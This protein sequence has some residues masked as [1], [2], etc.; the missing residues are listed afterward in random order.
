VH[1]KSR[2]CTSYLPSTT[3]SHKAASS[4]LAIAVAIAVSVLVVV[5][6]VSNG[7][8]GRNIVRIDA[9]HTY[10]NKQKQ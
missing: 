4:V 8:I 7:L 6:V 3:N 1:Q 10:R 9:P 5:V 2:G